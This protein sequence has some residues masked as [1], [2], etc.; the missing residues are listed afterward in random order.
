[1]NKPLPLTL[2]LGCVTLLAFVFVSPNINMPQL[3]AVASTDTTGFTFKTKA[4]QVQE[5]DYLKVTVV[6]PPNL[7]K[8]TRVPIQ[9]QTGTA[10]G[11]DVQ[12]TTKYITF[13]VGGLPSK[14]ISLK[15]N[16]DRVVEQPETFS[17]KIGGTS[18]VATVTILE[19]GAVVTTN[20]NQNTQ[21]QNNQTTNMVPAN[22]AQYAGVIPGETRKASVVQRS[23]KPMVLNSVYGFSAA[24][25]QDLVSMQDD[26][27]LRAYA[28]GSSS[29]WNPLTIPSGTVLAYK[30]KTTDYNHPTWQQF[31]L[32]DFPLTPTGAIAVSVSQCPGDLTS[33]EWIP[34]NCSGIGS[35]VS[36]RLDFGVLQTGEYACN[37]D[38]NK[39]YYLNISAGF[40]DGRDKDRSIP[41]IGTFDGTNATPG[42]SMEVHAIFWGRVQGP[43]QSGNTMYDNLIKNKSAYYAEVRRAQGEASVVAQKRIADCRAE[44]AKAKIRTGKECSSL[45]MPASLTIQ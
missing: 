32:S 28:V 31:E 1:M 9:I 6:A 13:Y 42:T 29:S 12:T 10:S 21:T 26:I 14:T 30:I 22:C 2:A 11:A 23:F 44:I 33:T 5:G 16:T 39:T 25:Q 19:K 3:A 38:L 24:A 43:S 4:A 41:H 8:T 34:K 40:A 15:T 7:T 45:P 36:T 35:Q 27:G 20:N 17:L 37:L 18:E